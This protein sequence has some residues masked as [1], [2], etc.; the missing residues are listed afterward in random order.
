MRDHAD[1]WKQPSGEST[2]PLT[3][4]DE[5]AYKMI[6]TRGHMRTLRD[7]QASD[8]HA[9]MANIMALSALKGRLA[10]LREV[11]RMLRK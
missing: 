6:E 5:L 2:D 4:R 3:L 11:G 10:A 7:H 1:H 8:P 9:L